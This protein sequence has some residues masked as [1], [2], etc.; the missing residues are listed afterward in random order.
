[1]S[2]PIV[3]L[4]DVATFIRNGVSL[5][6]SSEASGLKITRIETIADRIVN[7]D[8]CG[9]A[10]LGDIDYP[11]YRLK[12]GDILIS[13]I[14]SEKH[15]G[16][17][18]IFELNRD[19]I[20]HGMNL[21]CFRANDKVFPKYVFYYLSSPQFLSQLPTITK[22]SVNQASFTVTNFKELEIPLPPLTEQKRIASILDKADAIRRKRQQAID[23]ADE[24]LR[25]VF[26]DM[27]GDPVMNPK[28]WKVKPLKELL[29]SIDSG[30]SPKCESRNADNKEWG[31]LKLSAV[32]Y[33]KYQEKENKAFLGRQEDIEKYEVTSG[34]L[35]FTRKNTKDLV[36]AVAYVFETKPK[37]AMP[38]LIFRLNVKDAD[39][40]DKLYL[41][42]LLSNRTQR[43]E[44]QNLAGGAAGSM[45]NI[46]KAK[47]LN[48]LVPVPPIELQRKY[49]LIIHKTRES[50]KKLSVA[51]DNDG[52]LFKSLSQ[53][54]LS[55]EL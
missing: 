7:L 19:D 36:A 35:L 48:V 5:K 45:P 40:L 13:H 42:G 8:K 26:L 22:K 52:L 25:A 33:G 20:V 47:L 23:L 15:L 16:K 14:N 18:A 55:G 29:S 30:K 12:R 41:F 43:A 9:Y 11:E 17:C 44:I 37:R 28:G 53:K 21:L 39:I 1:M 2:W 49:A 32:T 24:F 54:A 51:S 3:T 27:F 4:G 31:V 46:S 34:D 10:D 6:Q 50:R 38:D